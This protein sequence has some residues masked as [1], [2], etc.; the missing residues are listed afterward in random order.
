MPS[1]HRPRDDE[2]DD[3]RPARRRSR[4]EFDDRGDYPDSRGGSSRRGAAAKTVNVPGLIGLIIGILGL[5]F[6]A[7][8]CTFY[9]GLPIAAIGLILGLI[10]M[11]SS[12]ETTG[13]GLPIAA[14]LVSIAGVIVG[15]VWLLGVVV[16]VQKTE[17]KM[18]EF[19]QE[20]KAQAKIREE[21]EKKKEKELRE[22]K[23]VTVTADQLYEEY[24]K[25]PLSADTKYKDK[26]LEV[27]G[28]VLRVDRDN[29]GRLAIEL[30]AT[31][32]GLIRCEF[33]RDAKDQ[34]EKVKSKDRIVIRGRCT[35]TSGRDQVKLENCLLVNR[36]K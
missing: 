26:V 15:V 36:G 29:F 5:I 2:F 9:I 27:T 17:E 21:E 35:G 25:N 12:R 33:A 34:L 7:I 28:T 16:F 32:D 19:Q 13:R 23:A 11:F 1:D 31:G 22:G 30:D 3:D 20:V 6:A 10:G 18:E 8:P 24:D 4:D 14:L